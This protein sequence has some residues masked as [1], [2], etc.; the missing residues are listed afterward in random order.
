MP[1][2]YHIGWYNLTVIL[3]FIKVVTYAHSYNYVAN[4][5]IVK[6]NSNYLIPKLDGTPDTTSQKPRAAAAAAVAVVV[7]VDNSW[8]LQPPATKALTVA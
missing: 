4:N 7:A 6:L 1:F 8:R 3:K 2:K 5:I